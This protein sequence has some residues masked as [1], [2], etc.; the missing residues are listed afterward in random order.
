MKTLTLLITAIAMP[1]LLAGCQSVSDRIKENPELFDSL[2]RETQARIREGIIDLGYTQDMVYL[3]LGEPNRKRKT[4]T[5]DG[6]TETWIYNTY[7]QRYDGQRMVGYDRTIYYD[8][9]NDVYRV[10]YTP[11]Y[12]DTYV[13][14]TEERI[15][16]VFRNDEAVSIEQGT[17]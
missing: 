5:T 10:F 1:V 14:E 13:P 12:T 8:K 9:K 16:I 7:F 11:R 4:S 6:V 15:R 17:D 2:D 3:A